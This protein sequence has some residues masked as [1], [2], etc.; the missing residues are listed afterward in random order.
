MI[1]YEVDYVSC[2]VQSKRLETNSREMTL[3]LHYIT[4]MMLNQNKA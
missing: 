3:L 1:N 4:R 2:T